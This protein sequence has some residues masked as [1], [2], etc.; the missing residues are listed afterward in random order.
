MIDEYL[1]S[2]IHY[3]YVKPQYYG[4]ENRHIPTFRK[5]TG[6]AAARRGVDIR[7]FWK[8]FFEFCI[9]YICI[10]NIHPNV[11]VGIVFKYIYYKHQCRSTWSNMLSHIIYS[12]TG[13]YISKCILLYI[14]YLLILHIY[15]LPNIE[16]E[17]FSDIGRHKLFCIQKHPNGHCIAVKY[18]M[19]FQI[20]I[21]WYTLVLSV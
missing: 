13:K 8:S 20:F 11:N 19:P 16:A 5:S 10:I 4:K 2:T 9:F 14:S 15:T 21:Y 17:M 1:F 7:F 3:Y 6:A 12:F 18:R